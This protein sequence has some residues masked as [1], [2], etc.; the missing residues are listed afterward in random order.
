MART[1][2]ERVVKARHFLGYADRWR[3]FESQRAVEQSLAAISAESV[4]V[5]D[6]ILDAIEAIDV[7]LRDP[8]QA[9]LRIQ[10]SKVGSIELPGAN[11]ISMLRSLGKQ[12]VGRLSNLL[13]VAVIADV[14]S[15][16]QRHGA[17]GAGTDNYMLHG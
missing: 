5:V 8:T 10:A 17:L 9:Q 1:A 11:E 13:G 16:S 7:K 15:S 6:E 3:D 2:Q 12:E 14:F 4:V